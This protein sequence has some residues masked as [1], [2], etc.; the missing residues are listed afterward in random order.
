M[1][2]LAAGEYSLD[3]ALATGSQIEHTQQV[4]IRD[5]LVLRCAGSHAGH[6]LMGVPMAGISLVA[7]QGA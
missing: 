2:L 7:E 3:V 5:A 4:W 6:G 1:P